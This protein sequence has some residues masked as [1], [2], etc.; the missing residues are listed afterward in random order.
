MATYTHGNSRDDILANVRGNWSGQQVP[1]SVDPRVL[2]A[3]G[4]ESIVGLLEGAGFSARHG[5]SRLIAGM[6]QHPW[7][8]L[9][10][11]GGREASIELEVNHRRYRLQCAD[12]P[13]LR[14]VGISG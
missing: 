7:R 12:A 1:G 4:P 6:Q 2:A 10:A 14:V 5:A 11:G 3:P 8:V 9:S 13:S